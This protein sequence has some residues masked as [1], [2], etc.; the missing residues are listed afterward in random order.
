M[1][2]LLCTQ[3]GRFDRLEV[4]DIPSPRPGSR[5]TRINIKAA[6]VSFPD[7]LTVQGLYQ[8][9][10]SLPFI[11]GTEFAGVVGE[12]GDSV[13]EFEVG[14]RVVAFGL[15][16]LAEE[17]L[18]DA[19][20]TIILP[21]GMEFDI[22]AG[23]I[24]SY[25]TALHGLRDCAHLA[26]GETLLVLA[27]AGGAGHAALEI[28]LAMGARV[29]AAASSDAKLAFCLQLGATSVINYSTEDLRNRIKILT[30]GRGVDVVYDPVGGPY[31][32]QAL[33]ATAWNGRLLVIGFAAG[34][35]A[36]IPLNHCLLNER[37]VI[38]VYFGE[39]VKHD[40]TRH[41]ANVEQLLEWFACGKIKPHISARVPL[42]LAA[43]LMARIARREI[44]GKAIVLPEA[45]QR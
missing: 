42:S 7:A 17:A 20:R 14:D 8:T 2:A 37:S 31:T 40:P 22:G 12:V 45:G 44:S 9:R 5:Q 27:A 3:F 28:G 1:R 10:P 15:G 26:T 16:G 11:P 34:E 29:I 30:E 41:S 6:S 24:V 4:V 33:R 21:E 39:S 23:F 13:T 36:K 32:E 25:G 43:Q 18:A 38:G 19:A 35:I